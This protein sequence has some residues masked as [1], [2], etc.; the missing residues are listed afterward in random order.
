M[1]LPRQHGG[2]G[3]RRPRSKAVQPLCPQLRRQSRPWPLTQLSSSPLRDPQ[4]AGFRSC[5]RA[6]MPQVAG[7]G[8][9]GS[10][11]STT[12]PCAP[13]SV[14]N[15]HTATMRLPS[16][17]VLSLPR[18][19]LRT[20]LASA[21]WLASKAAHAKHPRLGLQHWQTVRALELKHEEFRTAMQ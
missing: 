7:C 5:G 14:R 13:W 12:T 4:A 3:L 6:S 16:A 19:M 10:A 18:A 17:K 9:Q 2:L 1:T 21:C 15:G 11:P 8:H 20:T